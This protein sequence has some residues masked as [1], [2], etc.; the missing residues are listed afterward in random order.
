MYKDVGR[1]YLKA[2][3]VNFKEGDKFVA[4]E[5]KTGRK[6]LW[7]GVC[8]AVSS[9]TKDGD[10]IPPVTRDKDGKWLGVTAIDWEGQ[11]RQFNAC[12]HWG[13]LKRN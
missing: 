5:R 4:Y 12:N 11:T 8:E 2:I 6:A 7:G 3:T 13:F 1:R 9:F 10:K